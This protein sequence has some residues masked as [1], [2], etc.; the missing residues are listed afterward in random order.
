MWTSWQSHARTH[1]Q[2]KRTGSRTDKEAKDFEAMTIDRRVR[3]KR[4]VQG[5]RQAV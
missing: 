1:E 4:R 3:S 2:S 5:G